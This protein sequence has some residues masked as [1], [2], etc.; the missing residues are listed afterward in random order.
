M[1]FYLDD[2]FDPKY[3]KW[4]ADIKSNEFK[5][6]LTITGKTLNGIT[7]NSPLA[8]AQVKSCVLLAGLHADSETT[9][10]EPFKSRNHT[11]LMLKYLGANIQVNGNEVSIQKSNLIP[12]DIQIAGDISSAAFFI[13]AALIIPNSE[14]TIKNVSTFDICNNAYST[15]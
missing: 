12:K 6:P 5:L 2:M 13:V 14:I 10:K 7:Y 1:T 11:E 3:L 8:S 15:A 9:V 4:V